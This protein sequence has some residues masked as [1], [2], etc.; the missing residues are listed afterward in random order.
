MSPRPCVN[1]G[2]S[3]YA[4]EATS[5]LAI[6]VACILAAGGGCDRIQLGHDLQHGSFKVYDEPNPGQII[7]EIFLLMDAT[8]TCNW[9]VQVFFCKYSGLS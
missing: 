6:L 7:A 9:A 1:N 5:A 3:R 4:G 8:D 2:S